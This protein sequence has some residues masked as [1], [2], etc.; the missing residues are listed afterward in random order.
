[1]YE[2]LRYTY[3]NKMDKVNLNEYCTYIFSTSGQFDR[4]TFTSMIHDDH[5]MHVPWISNCGKL[6]FVYEEIIKN[7]FQ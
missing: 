4:S 3:I 1:M 6:S 7:Q 5:Y 2:L